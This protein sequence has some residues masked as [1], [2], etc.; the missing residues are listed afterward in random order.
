[1][2]RMILAPHRIGAEL[3]H[4]KKWKSIDKQWGW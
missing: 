2:I 3:F 4:T 1:M